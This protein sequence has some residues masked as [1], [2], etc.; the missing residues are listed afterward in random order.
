MQNDSMPNFSDGRKTVTA[1]GTRERLV[2]SATRAKK[3][4]ITGLES[5]TDM[6][7]VGGVT[8]V[9]GATLDGGGTRL[10]TPISAGQTL[11]MYVEDLYDIYLDAVVSGEGVS[12]TYYY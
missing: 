6:I 3:V 4:E 5:N 1:A 12:Y 2:A 8:V 9:A 10:G 11:T 7:V